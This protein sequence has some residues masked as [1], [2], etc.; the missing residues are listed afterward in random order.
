MNPEQYL[1]SWPEGESRSTKQIGATLAIS[2]AKA[3]AICTQAEKDGKIAKYGY[4]VAPGV[5]ES[6][7]HSNL[8][9]SSLFWQRI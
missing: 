6:P 9:P 3:Y 8:R 7:E 2:T 4:R 5:W 1:A